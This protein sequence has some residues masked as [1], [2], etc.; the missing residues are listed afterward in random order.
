MQKRTYT[1]LR[2]ILSENATGPDDTSAAAPAPTPTSGHA[3]ERTRMITVP[4][5]AVEP[6]VNAIEQVFDNMKLQNVAPVMLAGSTGIGKTSFVKQLGKLLGLNVEIIEVPHVAEEHLINIP[7]LIQKPTGQSAQ[8]TIDFTQWDVTMAES[9]LASV[10]KAM[11]PI[12]DTQYLANV[13]KFDKNLRAI[14]EQLGGTDDTIP[15][16]ISSIRRRYRTILFLDEF[17]RKSSPQVQNIIRGLLNKKIGNDP[18]P[19]GVY[20]IY[21]SN[22]RDVGQTVGNIPLNY[23]F[24]LQKFP[25]PTKDEF[26]HHFIS[27]AEKEGVKLVPELIN[28]FYKALGDEHI[29]HDDVETGI[30]TSPRRWEQLLLFINSALPIKNKEQAR[31]LMSNIQANFSNETENS[32]ILGF[33]W[34]IVGEVLEKTG[35]EEFMNEPPLSAG[36]WR[37]TLEQQIAAKIKLGDNRSYIPVVMG[38]P[39]IG[40]TAQ[41][42]RIAERLNLLLIEI[43]VSTLDRDSFIGMPLPRKTVAEAIAALN[44]AE[45]STMAVGFSAQPLYKKIMAEAEHAKETFLDDPNVPDAKKQAWQNQKFKYL[46]VFDEFNRTKQEVFNSMRRVILDKKFDE[47]TSLSSDMIVVCAM[48]PTDIGTVELTGHMKDAIDLIDAAPSWR[49]LQDHM[50]KT[51]DKSM[52]NISDQAKKSAKH[53][54]DSFADTFTIKTTKDKITDDSRRFY[55][56]IGRE[57][58]YMSM[59][60]YEHLYAEIAAAIDRVVSKQARYPDASDFERAMYKAIFQKISGKLSGILEKHQIDS[61]QFIEN[62]GSWLE[63]ELPNI[64]IKRRETGDLEHMLDTVLQ[65][66]NKHLF[67]DPAFYNYTQNYERTKFMEDLYN[68]ID[69]LGEEEKNKLDLLAKDTVNK[70]TVE[71]GEVKVQ[72][73][74]WSKLEAIGHELNHAA[75]VYELSNDF[76]DAVKETMSNAFNEFKVD[77]DHTVHTDEL[78]QASS[79]LDDELKKGNR[80]DPDK[81]AQLQAEFEQVASKATASREQMNEYMTRLL[82]KLHA[83]MGA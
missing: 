15:E 64:M 67:D 17:L 48:N 52:S 16:E 70:K 13:K 60:E 62:V 73:E 35:S 36:Q 75:D 6:R 4:S 43:D 37:S 55:L 31:A 7:F 41:F 45:D 59:R 11:K 83:V 76:K 77:L 39:G 61:P 40:K 27:N 30:R 34:D 20:V 53:L 3:P 33:V 32:K 29:S 57:T 56:A 21:A 42:A 46:L 26:F 38:P 19:R 72:R 51:S 54:I 44:E 50:E 5:S 69:K 78:V 58:A 22:L 82:H 24:Q 28:A 12:S 68:Y 49:A 18:L 23:D 9:Y 47:H 10:L 79:N 14:Y 71:K 65:N 63:S 25:A 74:L 80:A 66:P 8:K 1:A 81:V 2:A